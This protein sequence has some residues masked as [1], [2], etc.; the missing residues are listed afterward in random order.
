MSP[1]KADIETNA[2]EKSTIVLLKKHQAVKHL[3]KDCTEWKKT[4]I[5]SCS[6]KATSKF[7]GC[8]NTQ[9][10][11]NEAAKCIDF[12]RDVQEFKILG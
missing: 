8:W 2:S 7:K 5:A 3:P 11:E 12:E 10:N 4:K 6:G 9:E 1:L